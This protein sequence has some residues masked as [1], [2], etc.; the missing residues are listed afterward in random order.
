[1]DPNNPLSPDDWPKSEAEKAEIMQK[2]P[3]REL[4]GCLWWPTWMSRPDILVA[5]HEASK[6][7]DKPSQKLWNHLTRIVRYLA[8]TQTLGVVMKRPENH[9][10]QIYINAF[11]DGD[12]GACLKSRKSR[13]GGLIEV[14]GQLIIWFSAMQTATALST[15]ESEFYGIVTISKVLLW[16]R[17]VMQVVYKPVDS[18][19]PIWCDNQ[20]AIAWSYDLPFAKRAKHLDL[21]LHVMK[22]WTAHKIVKPDYMP[23]D[24][25]PA[26]FLTKPLERVRFEQLRDRVMGPAELQNYFSPPPLTNQSKSL[27]PLENAQVA[28]LNALTSAYSNAKPQ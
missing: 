15:S 4:L 23:C 8:Y 14:H 6:H 2:Y 11:V 24:I 10:A 28:Y 7:V 27:T 5:V 19:I 21:R 22:E 25:M 17:N 12:W 13:T 18:P 16:L 1:M 3:F 9:S 26:D 20:A